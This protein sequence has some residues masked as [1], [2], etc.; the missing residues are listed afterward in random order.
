MKSSALIA[1]LAFGMILCI[2]GSASAFSVEYLAPNASI[3]LEFAEANYPLPPTTIAGRPVLDWLDA[4]S[5]NN[6]ANEWGYSG[7]VLGY[8]PGSFTM[9]YP[10][11][12]GS[13]IYA[14]TNVP[15]PGIAFA[16]GCDDNDGRG[17]F[18]VD[19]QLVAQMDYYSAV[20]VNFVLFVDGL[21]SSLHTI[22]LT[23]LGGGVALY[24]GAALGA[25]PEPSNLLVLGSGILALA[26][27]IR[28]RN[29]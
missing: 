22:Q 21:P 3:F 2:S 14:N 29:G 19:N 15:A 5:P 11:T 24:G 12:N 4:A 16:G 8:E 26:G 23:S 6:P 7:D 17:Q 13:Y 9:L 10:N 1:V 18:Y 28:R 20:P 25:V 27:M